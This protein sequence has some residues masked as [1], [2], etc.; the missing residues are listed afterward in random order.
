MTLQGTH[1][2]NR[3]GR[4]RFARMHARLSVLERCA[5]AARNRTA[6]VDEYVM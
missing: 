6:A 5:A 4:S 2:G 3:F 1:S